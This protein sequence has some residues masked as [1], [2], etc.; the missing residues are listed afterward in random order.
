[1]SLIWGR[2]VLKEFSRSMETCLNALIWSTCGPEGPEEAG[3]C[4]I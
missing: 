1:M 3:G 2:S 4:L